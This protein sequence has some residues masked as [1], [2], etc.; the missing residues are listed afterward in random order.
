MHAETLERLQREI[1][2]SAEATTDP[3]DR[4]VSVLKDAQ[5]TALAAAFDCRLH[6]VY[7]AA[8]DQNIWP[9]RYVRNRQIISAAEQLK[10]A[11]ATV[12]VVGAGGL[13]GTVILLLARMGIG[14]L[15]VVDGDV[16]DETNLNR[17]ALSSVDNLGTP[18]V[19]AAVEVVAAVNPGVRLTALRETI[20]RQ[21]ARQIFGG[22]DV[23]V[24]ALDNA[25][26]RLAAA[27]AAREI[28]IPFVHGA[29]AG[30]DAQVMTIFPQDTG[31]KLL[32]GEKT[33]KDDPQRPEAVLGVPAITPSLVASLQA[34]EVLKIL[35][36]R[37][38][39]LRNCL[40]HVD[41]ESSRFDVF[42]F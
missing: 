37:G 26:D 41:L 32:Y 22:V 28:G 17:Q 38:E 33:Q 39:S 7:A 31:L 10:L 29:L 2:S 42:S 34:M 4:T 36:Q 16:F 20:D 15:K 23:V 14:H 13:G 11:E 24:D 9:F 12:A 21:S 40:L 1:A 19:E 27:A 6:Q 25:P 5:A 30:F 18:K 8:L 35:L 3:A